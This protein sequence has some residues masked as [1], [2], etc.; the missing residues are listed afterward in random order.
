MRI[1]WLHLSDIHFNYRNFD[2]RL[3]RKDFI[4]RIE[5][6]GKSEG[7]THLFLTGDI[8]DKYNPG[9]D[10]SE[11]TAQFINNLIDAMGI[12]YN[13]VFIIPGNHDHNRD[14]TISLT[15]NAFSDPADDQRICETLSGF[16]ATNL[17]DLLC[18]FAKYNEIYKKIFNVDY[19]T[20]YNNPHILVNSSNTSV[21]KINTAW[22]ERESGEKLYCD[23]DRLFTL[24]ESNCDVLKKS[25]NIAIGHHPLEEFAPNEK[26]RILN[27][28]I[29]FGVGLYFCGHV[30]KPSIHF[31]E[32]YDVLQLSCIGGFADGFSEGGYISGIIDTDNNLYEAEFYNWNE[33]SWYIDSSLDGTDERGICFFNTKK[34]K[35]NSNISVIDFKLYDGNISRNDLVKTIGCEN[36]NVLSYVHGRIDQG[37]I[38]WELHE[39][40]VVSFS[41]DIKCLIEQNKDIHLFP[42]APIPLLIKLGFELQKNS[43]ITVYQY[44]R[45]N[46]TWVNNEDD[47]GTTFIVNESC[48]GKNELIVKIC[49]S[50]Q[51]DDRI[52]E[53]T[54]SLP[55]Y[56]L[57][58]FIASNIE[59]GSPISIKE[60]SRLVD[61]IF[62]HLN[63][64][65]TT[66]D[67][68]HLFAAV[69]AGMAVEI[70]RN[71]LKS[72]YYN[73]YTY[74]LFRGEYCKAIIINATDVQNNNNKVDNN[75]V[76]FEEYQQSIV[77]IPIVGK[78]ACGGASEPVFEIDEYAPMSKSILGN[79]EFFFLRASGDSM[80]GAGIDD[81]DLVL[82]KQQCTAEDGQIVV[83][84]IDNETTLK[85]FYRDDD[86][87]Q[88]VLKPENEMY[89]E[90]KY[91]SID[92]Q[93]IA[94][95]IIKDL[96]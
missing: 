19:Y 65:A 17:E 91:N 20:D 43:K 44:N 95:K 88:I 92:I 38:N 29:R 48:N 13:N 61:T 1:R 70:G 75:V 42:L 71:M 40:S 26:E 52:I 96:K 77:F 22:L 56:D 50:S 72:M 80:T 15:E 33:G 64:L 89:E 16:S 67:K 47:V 87:R 84:L 76:F 25:V 57:L 10:A 7:F 34:Y 49:T 69:P 51:I 78:I 66:Y 68:I 53:K 14:L 18:S 74:Q 81:G 27:L 2:S 30:H 45:S 58:E 59:L 35:H 60:V 4:N 39:K 36:F 21:I 54:F 62:M 23:T 9:D 12:D 63:K 41:Q 86:R 8:L 85:R 79:G 3:L 46:A 31:F 90:K 37:S 32:E 93:G 94:I 5:Q 83:A 6:L 82:I 73:V 24:M 11:E 55:E 28:F